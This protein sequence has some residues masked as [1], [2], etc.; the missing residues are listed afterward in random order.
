[1]KL[2]AAASVVL[3]WAIA[4]AC[5]AAAVASHHLALAQRIAAPWLDRQHESGSFPD[6]LDNLVPGAA[7]GFGARYGDAWMGMVLLDVGVRTGDERY[8]SAGLRALEYAAS[9]QQLPEWGVSVFE[10]FALASAYNVARRAIPDHPIFL[11][12][13]AAWEAFLRRIAIMRIS[14]RSYGNHYLVE[15]A[16][17]LELLRTGLGSTVHGAVLSRARRR[18]SRWL[19]QHLINV[20]IPGFANKQST[21]V[22]RRRAFVLSDR[23]EN[24]AA[25][26]GLSLAFYA[27]SIKLLGPRAS[28]AARRTLR[29]AARA[30]VALMAPTGDTAYHGRSQGQAWA[31]T[32]AIHGLLAARRGAPRFDRRAF[33]AAARRALAFLQSRYLGD[34]GLRVTPGIGQSLPSGARGVD[35]YTEEP[36][37]TAL[38]AQF[39]L[40]AAGERHPRGGKGP[41]RPPRSF[42]LGRGFSQLVILRNRWTWLAYRLQPSRRYQGDLRY[43][44]GLVLA[45]TRTPEGWTELVHA[46]PRTLLAIDG[47]GP[48]FHGEFGAGYPIASLRRLRRGEAKL[49]IAWRAADG[50]LVRRG[51]PFTVAIKGRCI[52]QR[53]R[54][55][56]G[57]QWEWS[58]VTPDAV[59]ASNDEIAFGVT[60]V[61]D[62]KAP[63]TDVEEGYASGMQA[64]LRRVRLRW[65]SRGKASAVRLCRRP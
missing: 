49:R 9:R 36:S 39:L 42:V 45:L 37:F 8:R 65:T 53:W 58:A 3:F 55:R 5:P 46:P 28:A 29:R 23:P 43:T 56:P 35:G 61:S 15:A 30:A 13:R 51:V 18:E 26:V 20:R 34:G 57:D 60:S 40:W 59:L 33:A 41:P 24:P 63:E 21:R 47:L 22:G 54:G 25:Y 10:R 2:R 52:L 7:P 50:R 27:R 11:R 19:A 48:L 31:T 44:S 1:V 14:H 32:G 6:A 64:H 16:T 12:A 38:T 4:C 17:V 62:P